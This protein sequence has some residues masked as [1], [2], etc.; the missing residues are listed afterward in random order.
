ML[1]DLS[2]VPSPRQ[3]RDDL[4]KSPLSGRGERTGEGSM[5]CLRLFKIQRKRLFQITKRFFFCLSETRHFNVQTTGNVILPFISS[6]TTAPL[7]WLPQSH[8]KATFAAA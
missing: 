5:K 8:P 3:E 6:D 7:V 2:L 4:Q 1:F